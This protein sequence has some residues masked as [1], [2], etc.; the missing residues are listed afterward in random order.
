MS[1]YFYNQFYFNAQFLPHLLIDDYV[2][3]G[4]R[5]KRKTDPVDMADKFIARMEIDWRE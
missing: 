2:D 5:R 4:S 3:G 1:Q